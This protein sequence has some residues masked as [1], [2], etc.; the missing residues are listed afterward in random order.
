MAHY[1][2]LNRM[3]PMNPQYKGFAGGRIDVDCDDENDPD[4]D[5][6]GNEIPV[7]LMDEES[8]D[9]LSEWVDKLVT[10]SLLDKEVFEM[11]EEDTG[12]NIGWYDVAD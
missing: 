8:W 6:Y 3:G 4:Y 7:P 10:D 11:F 5:K 1:Y 12:L 2:F 9:H